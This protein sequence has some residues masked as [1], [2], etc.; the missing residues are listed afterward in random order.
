M[1]E[2]SK[3]LGISLSS[4]ENYEA[5]SQ[6]PRSDTI[7][8]IAQKL[9]IS[10][11]MLIS[12]LPPA[13]QSL[14]A[15]LDNISDKIQTLHPSARSTAKHALDLL[16]F[17]V[18]SSEESFFLESHA[19]PLEKTTDRFRYILHESQSLLPSTPSYGI[20]VEE[21]LDGIWTATSLFAPFSND[22]TL[23]LHI[24]FTANELQ[25]PPSQFFSEVF[26][27]FFPIP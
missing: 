8:L 25:L 26:H 20:L 22:R 2:F 24:V 27:D 15:C 9:H 21:L 16:L 4:L 13:D 23:A 12:N 3:E 14:L 6:P 7:E 11:A 1:R 17:A 19:A 18:R 5:G 10:P